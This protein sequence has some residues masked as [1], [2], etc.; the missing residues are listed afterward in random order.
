MSGR[1]EQ[2]REETRRRLYEA[3]IRIFRE[4]GVAAARIDEIASEVGVSRGT[5]YFHFPSKDDVLAQMMHESQ[6]AMVDALDDFPA[7]TPLPEIL[8]QVAGLMARQWEQDAALLAEM[9]MVALRRT[10]QNLAELEESYPLQSALVP[11]FERASDRGEIHDLIPPVLLSEFF[12]V[13]L[14]GAALAW[15]GN[16]V[17]PLEEL[18]RNVVVFFLRATRAPEP[19]AP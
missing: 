13:N 12:L 7:A 6:E 15:C 9:G 18:L 16:P 3:S 10:A 2:K 8:S 19:D 1:R 17:V 5:F 11:W 4:Q 14:F